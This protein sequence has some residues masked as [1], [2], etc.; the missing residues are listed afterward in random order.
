MAIV[1]GAMLYT[2]ELTWNGG[3]GVKGEYQ[4]ATN[5]VGRSTLG[6]FRSAPLGIVSAEGSLTQARALLDHRRVRF[7]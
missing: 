1:Q 4:K 2:A 3:V 6:V 7:T 5:R